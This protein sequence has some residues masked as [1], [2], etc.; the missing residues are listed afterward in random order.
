MP[1]SI[2]Q[3]ALGYEP[4]TF[5]AES[6]LSWFDKLLGSVEDTFS[7][8]V[9]GQVSTADG[10]IDENGKFHP[11]TCLVAGTEILTPSGYVAI[12]EIHG[13]TDLR[14]ADRPDLRNPRTGSR[15]R[16]HVEPSVLYYCVRAARRIRRTDRQLAYHKY[17]RLGRSRRQR[18][19]AEPG[20]C[21]S[22]SQLDQCAEPQRPDG[23]A[24]SNLCGL[25]FAG[26]VPEH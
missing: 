2:D 5:G 11:R 10:F 18:R 26:R 6:R 8:L 19:V 25:I 22:W 9:L 7:E 14:A 17:R 3:E 16:N 23:S 13:N 21:R 1:A 24:A 4:G 20:T 15:D 12:E